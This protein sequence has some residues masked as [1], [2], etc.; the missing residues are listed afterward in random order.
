MDAAL[1]AVIEG[2]ID[3][4]VQNGELFTAWDVTVEVR[5]R[6]HR[7]RHNNIKN[8][9]HDYFARGQMGADYNRTLINVPGAPIQPWCYHRFTDD[10]HTSYNPQ[11]SKPQK[12]TPAAVAAQVAGFYAQGQ[13]DDDGDDGSTTTVP[14]SLPAVLPSVAGFRQ[15]DARGT[16]CVPADVLRAAGF[17]PKDTA[18][19][20]Q[21]TADTLKVCKPATGGKPLGEYTVDENNNVRITKHVLQN[22]NGTGAGYDFTGSGSQV[23]VSAK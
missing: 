18:H 4:K 8:V 1:T 20:W 13:A 19:V 15:P 11:A 16:V 7:D 14:A 12:T 23:L 9:V 17:K 2:V 6:G 21:H 5:N 3:D 10:P 22:I